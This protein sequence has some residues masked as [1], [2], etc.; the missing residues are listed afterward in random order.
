M[1]RVVGSGRCRVLDLELTDKIF[2]GR[3]KQYRLGETRRICAR[4]PA[5]LFFYCI[6][7]FGKAEG[8]FLVTAGTPLTDEQPPTGPATARIETSTGRKKK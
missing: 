3:S 2:S 1:H 4:R 6:T 7:Q 5:L 8:Y